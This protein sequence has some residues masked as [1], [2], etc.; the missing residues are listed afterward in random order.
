LAVLFF[1]IID[2]PVFLGCRLEGVGRRKE[3]FEIW[4]LRIEKGRNGCPAVW[5]G[6]G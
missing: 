5:S 2:I 6:G 4:D 3:E 1:G